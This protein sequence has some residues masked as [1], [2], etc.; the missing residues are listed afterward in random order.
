LSYPDV[1]AELIQSYK[2]I[3][4]TTPLGM[5]PNIDTFPRLPYE[6]IGP[7]H[8]LYDLVYNPHLTQFLQKGLKNGAQCKNGLEMLHIQADK[9][10]EI[11]NVK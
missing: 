3:I 10:W 1:T 8:L 5:Y 9:A 4:N 2:L 6:L 7:D 11:W